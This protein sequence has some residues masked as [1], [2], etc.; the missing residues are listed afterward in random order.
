MAKEDA[1]KCQMP[2][3]H[4][5]QCDKP[6]DPCRWSVDGEIEGVPLCFV[7]RTGVLNGYRKLSEVK[8]CEKQ[9]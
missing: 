5:D 7:H 3:I 8:P 9:T 6:G 1:K 2:L 4:N